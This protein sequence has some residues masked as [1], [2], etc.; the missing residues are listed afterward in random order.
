MSETT[1]TENSPQI[2]G[3]MAAVMADIQAVGKT[4]QAPAAAGGYSYRGIDD[5]YNAAQPALAKHRVICTPRIVDKTIEHT[6][7]ANGKAAVHVV[8]TVDHI[9]Y[10]PDGSSVTTTTLG[11]ALDI[12]DKAGNKA[13]AAAYKYAIMLTFCVPVGD[14]SLD[15][16]T[17]ND[18]LGAPPPPVPAKA[19][20]PKFTDGRGRP[21]NPPTPPAAPPAKPAGPNMDWLKKLC[22][23]HDLGAECAADW[24]KHFGAKDGK[25]Y[26]RLSEL[27]QTQ[28]D[29][30]CVKVETHYANQQNPAVDK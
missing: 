17:E 18:E 11:E 3:L 23:K 13:M 30:I 27:S 22:Q 2:Y 6:K 28:I 5:L 25:I 19:A 16:E 29:A 12:G 14:A 24:L 15:T 9:W 1:A 8:I 20:P 7:T 4:R 21:V 10:A 26:T